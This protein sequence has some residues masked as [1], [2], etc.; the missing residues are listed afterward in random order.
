MQGRMPGFTEDERV[1]SPTP[2]EWNDETVRAKPGWIALGRTSLAERAS[3]TGEL[4][5]CDIVCPI[6]PQWLTS[7]AHHGDDAMAALGGEVLDRGDQR[8]VGPD[9]RAGLGTS[10]VF[11][12]QVEDPGPVIVVDSAMGGV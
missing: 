1:R 10:P 9:R 5:A 8:R 3:G 11:P 4:G 7:R 6:S 12:T 2:A